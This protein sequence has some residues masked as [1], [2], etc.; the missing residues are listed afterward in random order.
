MKNIIKVSAAILLALSVA[1]SAVGATCKS[2]E[3][4]DIEGHIEV[5]W[6]SGQSLS[7]TYFRENSC[8]WGDREDLNGFDAVVL[9]VESVAGTPGSL[10]ADVGNGLFAIA[11]TGEFLDADCGSV[12][13][14]EPIQQPATGKT[15]EVKIPAGSKWLLIVPDSSYPSADVEL[16]LHSDGKDCPKKK[17]QKGKGR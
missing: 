6:P 14:S 8:T 15:Y 5:T 10:T 2:V 1:G 17:A 13:G 12:E 3:A 11:I 4:T 7:A 9:D 16:V